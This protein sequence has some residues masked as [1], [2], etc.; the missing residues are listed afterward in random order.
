MYAKLGSPEADQAGFLALLG[1][2][3]R[4]CEGV[5][6]CTGL[7]PNGFGPYDGHGGRNL[8][9]KMN[10]PHDVVAVHTSLAELEDGTKYQQL[11][12]WMN[13]IGATHA[14]NAWADPVNDLGGIEGKQQVNTS[15]ARAYVDRL[16]T[17]GRK[18][19]ADGMD[20]S[21]HNH[22]PEFY[23]QVDGKPFIT[24]ML[25][26]S[27][28]GDLDGE[29]LFVQLDTAWA[30]AGGYDPAQ[31]LID[32]P[33]RVIGIHAK[34]IKFSGEG[35]G[36]EKSFMPLGQGDLKD[37][38]P[39]VVEAAKADPKVRGVSYEQDFHGR[40]KNNNLIPDPDGIG[41]ADPMRNAVISL[42]HLNDLVENS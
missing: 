13:E 2:L 8:S 14:V 35:W 41:L 32:F 33:G 31:F 29:Y 11:T 25:N 18:L 42:T 16:I 10:T 27:K 6:L 26:L 9:S 19:R 38:N 12:S 34:D 23:L 15:V 24:Y 28:P 30:L 39:E 7:M 20:F 3:D 37:V 22:H 40:D 1:G 36:L 21:L 17:I 5:E 4:L